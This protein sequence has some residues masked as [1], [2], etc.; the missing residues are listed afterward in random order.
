[1]RHVSESSVNILLPAS[2]L[3][4]VGTIHACLATNTSILYVSALCS[5]VAR[6]WFKKKKAS[7]QPSNISTIPKLK[8][9]PLQIPCTDYLCLQIILFK[10]NIYTSSHQKDFFFSFIVNGE[11]TLLDSKVNSVC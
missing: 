4:L 5:R 6:S 2:S 8:I 11:K 3:S 7:Q 10:S 9:F 1:M